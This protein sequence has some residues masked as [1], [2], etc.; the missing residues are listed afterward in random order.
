MENLNLFKSLAV[1]A[2]GLLV[3]RTVYHLYFHP[4]SKFPGPRLAAATFLY[5]FYYDVWKGGMYIWEVERMH[6]KYGPIVRI[7]PREL[8]IK[9]PSYYD[10]IH[11]GSSRKRSKD[12]QYSV[13]Y[14]APFSLVGTTYH[15]HHRFRRGL[16]SNYF[17]KRSV[18]ELGPSIHEKV[19]KLVRRFEKAYES[20]SVLILQ[21]DLAA[22][23]T[24][25]ITDYCYGWSYGYLDDEKPARSNDLVDAV[26][27]LMLMFHINRFF[28]FLIT[29]FRNAPPSL[30]RWLQ[31]KMADLF[32]FKGRLRRQA[33]S[34]LQRR[35][36][37]KVATEGRPNVFDA[38]TN[39]D[40]PAHE[41]TLDRLEDESALLLG[42]GTE[43]TAR[44]IAVSMFHL[45]ANK[46]ILEKLRVE[47]RT[48]LETPQSR[49]SWSD[50]EKLPYLTGVVNEGLRLSHGMTLRLA[51]VSPNEPMFYKDW[52]I[53]AG[54]PVSQSN[55][56]VHMDATLFP[57]P[58]KFDPERWVRA[59][60][61]GE[62]LSRYI[63]S[64]TKG[65][66][67]CLGMNLAY[68]EIY[69][70]LAHIA[71]RIDFTLYET[72]V[73]NITVYRDKAIGCPEVGLF[74]VRATVSGIVEE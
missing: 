4:L 26:N 61:N 49:A 23:T 44:A 42:A 74:N 56:F 11:A 43:T 70:A 9:D 53:P 65:S 16:L 59:A 39:L 71:R 22:L 46:D 36:L 52:T 35:D 48:V 33:K 51:R 27:G 55:Y 60:D 19:G 34:T 41:R 1:L 25:I 54:T 29:V 2:L 5:E 28:P 67:Q 8:H 17:S 24:D 3:L 50:L 12:V 21:L 40:I 30:V 18:M 7:N 66:R 10:E 38:L 57:E 73:E 69:L 20:G 47:L 58:K 68:A 31:P 64:F 32:E 37:E 62:Y 63:V 15:D 14:G 13:A 45:I 6:E 72:T